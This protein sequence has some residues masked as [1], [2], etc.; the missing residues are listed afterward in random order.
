MSRAEF[1]MQLLNEQVEKALI[2]EKALQEAIFHEKLTMDE[3]EQKSL[4]QGVSGNMSR[5]IWAIFK[6]VRQVCYLNGEKKHIV[7]LVQ[8][9]EEYIVD[10]TIRQFLPEEKRKVFR[11]KEYPLE[12][13]EVQTWNRGENSITLQLTPKKKQKAGGG[14]FGGD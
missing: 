13:K 5:R 11:L 3:F 14:H 6:Q 10:G 4:C 9:E 1:E 8:G 7:L 12:F 2:D